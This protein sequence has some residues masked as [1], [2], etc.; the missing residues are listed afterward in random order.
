M[1]TCYL[2]DCVAGT[3]LAVTKNL[4]YNDLFVIQA[5]AHNLIIIEVM[6]LALLVNAVLYLI[7]LFDEVGVRY[8]LFGDVSPEFILGSKWSDVGQNLEAVKCAVFT[9]LVRVEFIQRFPPLARQTHFAFLNLCERV[10]ETETVREP[11]GHIIHQGIETCTAAEVRYET[12]GNFC[13]RSAKTAE[14]FI[15]EGTGEA[16][17]VL[18]GSQTLGIVHTK[19]GCCAQGVTIDTG[20]QTPGD[21]AAFNDPL[22]L[23]LI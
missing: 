22:P 20:H 6:L 19:S 11:V 16:G 13:R 7:H 21:S 10:A 14:V 17:Y 15:P 12:T 23:R 4:G 8:R 5:F 1:S 2:I 18:T 3:E 9:E